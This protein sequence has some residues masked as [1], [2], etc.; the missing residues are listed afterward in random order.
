MTSWRRSGP[1]ADLGA[2]P[3]TIVPAP[4]LSRPALPPIAP[5]QVSVVPDALLKVPVALSVAVLVVVR[6]A[7]VCK[8][9]LSSNSA[10]D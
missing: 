6:L 10:P 9:P 8:V 1:A 7:V 4:V 5:F 3:S 2:R